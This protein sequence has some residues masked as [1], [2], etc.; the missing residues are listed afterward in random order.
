MV[1]RNHDV[2]T[3]LSNFL[4]FSYEYVYGVNPYQ[5]SKSKIMSVMIKRYPVIFPDLNPG[6]A[7]LRQSELIT[8]LREGGLRDQMTSNFHDF[9]RELL[10]KDPNDRLGSDDIGQEILNHSFVKGNSQ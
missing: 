1:D 3:S 8:Q 4:I 7:S 2:I 6:R 9:I 5:N 10:V